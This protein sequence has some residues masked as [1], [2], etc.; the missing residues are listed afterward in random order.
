MLK[1]RLLPLS[2]WLTLSIILTGMID[3]LIC[4]YGLLHLFCGA[5]LGLRTREPSLS[6]GCVIEP[7]LISYVDDLLARD[8]AF[9]EHLVNIGQVIE[10]LESTGLSAKPSKCSICLPKQPFLGFVVDGDVRKPDPENVEAIRA[11]PEPL[12]RTA[13]QR[14]LGMTGHYRDFV[15]DYSAHTRARRALTKDDVPHR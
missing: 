9:E 8:Q 7:C 1:Y 6:K 2:F 15:E 14:F 4:D 12:N 5:P 3:K 13:V 10:R 11:F